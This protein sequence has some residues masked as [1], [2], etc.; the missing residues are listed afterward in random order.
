MRSAASLGRRQFVCSGMALAATTALEQAAS[1]TPRDRNRPWI[2]SRELLAD[3]PRIMEVASLPG[4]SMAVVENGAVIWT[5][6]A[7]LANIETRA[8]VTEDSVFEAAS[9]SKPVFAYVVLRL[10]DE[11][12]I[13]LDRPL[14]HYY[15]PDY[16]TNHPNIDLITARDVLRHS[17][18]LPNWRARPEDSLTPAFKPGSRWRYSGEGFFWLQLV[19]EHITGQGL[20]TVMRSR[21]FGPAGMPLS[22]F[23]WNPEIARLSVY[24]HTSPDEE[25]VKLGFQYKRE[26]GDRFLAVAAKGGKPISEWTYDDVLRALPEAMTLPGARPLP[27]DMAKAPMGYFKLPVNIF[28]NVAGMLSTTASEYARFMALMLDHPKHAPWEITETS[29][30]AMLSHQMMSKANTIYWGLGWGL[31]SPPSGPV[32]FH[33]GNNGGQFKTFG[34]GDPA[35]RRAIVI[36][37]NGGSG[38][39]V[40][41]RIIREATGHDL[42]EFLL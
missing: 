42:W 31:E 40:Y 33:G 41:Q 11:Q 32:F 36:F 38:D 4:L 15:K 3:L 20:D 24:C 9:M 14:V 7:G 17:T 26:M 23:G 39:K 18:G 8:P 35:R 2:P 13:D 29:W 6:A 1:S 21:L 27:A 5:H 16:L 34:L 25:D 28:S 19:V 10:S 12:L 37:T 22:T 30:H